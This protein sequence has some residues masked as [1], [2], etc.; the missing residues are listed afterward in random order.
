[1]VS[2]ST[3]GH[4]RRVVVVLVR[5]SPITAALLLGFTTNFAPRMVHRLVYSETRRSSAKL[6]GSD[7]VAS[8]INNVTHRNFDDDGASSFVRFSLSAW[9]VRDLGPEVAPNLKDEAIRDSTLHVRAFAAR[10]NYTE[11]VCFYQVFFRSR[12]Y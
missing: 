7:D 4:W 1:M 12:V 9:R 6:D 5:L 3:I 8:A 2:S 10:M 11:Q